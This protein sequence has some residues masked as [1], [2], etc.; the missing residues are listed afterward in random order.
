[1][2][3]HAMQCNAMH[4]YIYICIYVY[5]HTHTHIHVCVYIYIYMIHNAYISFFFWAGLWFFEK[6]PYGELNLYMFKLVDEVTMWPAESLASFLWGATKCMGCT[7]DVVCCLVCDH[8]IQLK[9]T[10]AERP[11]RSSGVSTRTAAGVCA[12]EY[13]GW[14][15]TKTVENLA[16]ISISMSDS[17]VYHILIAR[18]HHLHLICLSKE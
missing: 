15:G 4:V 9:M 12:S 18:F 16:K 17:L 8:W 6:H 1:M 3:C 5:E 10:R 13:F 14:R 2:P 7:I 11:L